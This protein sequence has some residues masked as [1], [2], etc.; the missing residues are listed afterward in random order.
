MI[1]G[2]RLMK[3]TEEQHMKQSSRWYAVIVAGGTGCRFGAMQ[4]KQFA[5]ID[6]MT[7]LERSV[8]TFFQ[9]TDLY[10]MIVV[11][12]GDWI[13]RTRRLLHHLEYRDHIL[14]VPGGTRRQDS[15]RQG[16]RALPDDPTAPVLIHDA[17]RPFV[18]VN[19]VQRVRDGVLQCDC[20]IPAVPAVD[21][22]VQ[23]E[24]G[25]A[26]DYPS[27]VAL[28][29]V[30]TPQGFRMSIIRSVHNAAAGDDGPGA[31]D[32]GSL[33]LRAG[34]AVKVID[35]EEANRKITVPS[36]LYGSEIPP[37]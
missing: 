15:C 11:A 23:I 32:D 36:D 9:C 16:L 18:S 17:A 7:V 24:N 12:H 22:I 5:V 8:R 10:R 6:G 13:E 2:D 37:A 21:S 4:P 3:S 30:Q 26:I 29:R 19:L 31:P 33:V 34:Y 28:G 35:G 1:G 27:R 25:L 14:I 20:V